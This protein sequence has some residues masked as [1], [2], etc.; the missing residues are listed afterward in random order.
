VISFNT[1]KILTAF[2]RAILSPFE[3]DDKHSFSAMTTNP[4]QMTVW[5]PFEASVGQSWLA[6]RHSRE[7]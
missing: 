7:M 5:P 1:F 2:R 4:V 3:G 6:S